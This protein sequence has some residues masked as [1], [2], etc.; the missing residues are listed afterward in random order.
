LAEGSAVPLLKR[1]PEMFPDILFE[2]SDECPWFVAH[3][4]SRQE[5]R[6][7]RSVEARGVP[8]YLPQR[9]KRT[10]RA[11]RTFV[12]HLPLFP[13]YVFF[14]GGASER[15][16]VLR[17]GLVVRLI[18]VPSQ[19]ELSAELGQLR[20]LQEHGADLTPMASIVQGDAVRVIDGPFRGYCGIVLREQG[21]CRLVVSISMLRQCVVV[22]LE[23]GSLAALPSASAD[24]RY[25]RRATA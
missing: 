6:L 21:R 15:G 17:S 16:A 18:E 11:G 22:D 3:T 9:E 5:K 23:R 12:S 24:L 25:L 10:R 7:V 2:M 20:R 13:G 8:F 19:G 1:G 4:R 14:R